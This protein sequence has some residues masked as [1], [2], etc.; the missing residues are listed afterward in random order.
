MAAKL[1]FLA[2]LP[3]LFAASLRAVQY[4]RRNPKG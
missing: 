4:Y 1:P 2:W 3:F